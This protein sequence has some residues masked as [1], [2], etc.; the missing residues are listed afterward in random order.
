MIG[1]FDSGVGGLTVARELKKYLPRYNL[2]YFGDAA[3]VPYGNKSQKIIE[4]YSLENTRFLLNQGADII[5]IACHTASALAA[6]T[7]RK[8]HPEVLIFDVIKAG[9]E[10]AAAVTKNHKIGIIG[11]RGTINTKTHEN[12]LRRLD[13]RLKIFPMACPLFVPLVEEFWCAKPETKRIIKAYLRPLKHSKIDT[14]VLACTHYP[15][16]KK[17]LQKFFTSKVRIIDP[18]VEM[19]LKLKD[20]ILRDNEYKSMLEKNNRPSVFF[21]SDVTP[22]MELIA[23]KIFRKR[24]KFSLTDLA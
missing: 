14:L 12:L 3:R 24:I 5:V 23:S 15:L 6:K 11:T 22:Q 17:N 4:K 19:A 18:G 16:L 1:V 9:L 2:I 7:I 13:P 20:V 10:K 8:K 21:A